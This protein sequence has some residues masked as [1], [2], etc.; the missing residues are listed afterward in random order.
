MDANQ[1]KNGKYEIIAPLGKGAM[2]V[3]YKAFDPID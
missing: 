3:V 1:Q 2:G